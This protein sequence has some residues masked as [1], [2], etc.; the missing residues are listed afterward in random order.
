MS[1]ARTAAELQTAVLAALD[2]ADVVIAAAK[3]GEYS[4]TLEA[5]AAIGAVRTTIHGLLTEISTTWGPKGNPLLVQ[6]RTLAA[7]LLDLR[8]LVDDAGATVEVTLA[9]EASL[10]E[11]AVEWYSDWERW[12]ELADLNRRLSK[13]ARIPA[14]TILVRYAQ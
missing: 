5:E 14:G 2:D 7:L 4:S 11:L 13:P 9:R 1:V 12:T 6:L 3:D 10:I 8:E